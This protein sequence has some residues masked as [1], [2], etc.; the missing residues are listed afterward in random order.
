[1][2]LRFPITALMVASALCVAL[3]VGADEPPKEESKPYNDAFL[4]CVVPNLARIRA[5]PR[6]SVPVMDGEPAPQGYEVEFPDYQL[7]FE[8]LGKGDTRLD[9]RS[10]TEESR[11]QPLEE[12]GKDK[13]SGSGGT[14][15]TTEVSAIQTAA[16]GADK[17][18]YFYYKTS[19]RSAFE[20]QNRFAYVGFGRLKGMDFMFVVSGMGAMK[21]LD[22]VLRF[23]ATCGFKR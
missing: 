4:S 16:L 7:N 17:V 20:R 13:P 1:M 21:D 3:L 11:K 12:K 10:W 22:P 15:L 5:L 9:P 2:R 23:F 14:I 6:G 19:V 18:Y 8:I